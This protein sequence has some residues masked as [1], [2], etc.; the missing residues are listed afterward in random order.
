MKT[1]SIS[2]LKAHLSKYLREIRRG[3]EVQVLDR[4]V[5]VA[6]LS[7]LPS[8]GGQDEGHRQRLIQAGVLRAGQGGILTV[9]ENPPLELPAGLLESLDEDRADRL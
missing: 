4:G 1:V 8:D 2:E 9:L 5:P 7:P 3:G 6:R